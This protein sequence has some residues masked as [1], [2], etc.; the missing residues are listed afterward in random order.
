MFIFNWIIIYTMMLMRTKDKKVCT[1][2]LAENQISFE[3]EQTW[4]QSAQHKQIRMCLQQ[5]H[6]NPNTSCLHVK[7]RWF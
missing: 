3:L 5:T 2:D 1:P 4:K 6:P 7:L